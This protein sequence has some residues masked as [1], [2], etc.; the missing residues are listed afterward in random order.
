MKPSSF[1]GA[2]VA[3]H[4]QSPSR[5]GLLVLVSALTA[6]ALCLLLSMRTTASALSF[7]MAAA[8]HSAPTLPEEPLSPPSCSRSHC[9]PL[10]CSASALFPLPLSDEA[11]KAVWASVHWWRPSVDRVDGDGEKVAEVILLVVD[12]RYA[13]IV[14]NS[15][16]SLLYARCLRDFPAVS[17]SAQCVDMARSSSQLR[18]SWLSG[19]LL[20]CLDAECYDFFTERGMLA[21]TVAQFPAP[22]ADVFPVSTTLLQS[23][24]EAWIYRWWLMWC[25][26]SQGISVFHSDGDVLYRRDPYLYFRRFNTLRGHPVDMHSGSGVFPAEEFA[27]LDFTLQGGFIHIRSNPRSL[28]FVREVVHS[29]FSSLSKDDQVAANA[30]LVD[31]YRRAVTSSPPSPPFPAALNA[32]ADVVA[33]RPFHFPCAA[34]SPMGRCFH[35]QLPSFTESAAPSLTVHVVDFHVFLTGGVTR[36]G[37]CARLPGHLQPDA[38]V[39][40]PTAVSKEKGAKTEWLQREGYWLLNTTAQLD[41]AVSGDVLLQLANDSFP[42]PLPL[43]TAPE[44]EVSTQ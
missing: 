6:L 22:P 5:A 3:L 38:F 42:L 7:S 24:S 44:V 21:M 31:W 23:I 36:Y 28:R 15:L 34:S 39:V 18:S 40:H 30:V 37:E 9:D 2:V 14:F 12:V 33:D 41:A 4:W 10:N 19:H 35:V 11:C 27:A 8:H 29:G 43:F 32:S 25:L 20:I 17:H 16:L 26:L 1:S 13:S